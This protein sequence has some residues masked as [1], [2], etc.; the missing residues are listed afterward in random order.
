MNLLIIEDEPLYANNL[1]VLAEKLG[2]QVIGVVDNAAGALQL[3]KQQVPDLALMD[4]NIAGEYDGVETATLLRQEA[5]FPIIFVTSLKDDRTFARAARLG[6]VNYIIK[7]FDDVQLQRAIMLALRNRPVATPPPLEEGSVDAEYLYVKVA[8]R[9]TKVKLSNLLLVSADGHYCELHTRDET[10]NNHRYVLRGSLVDM[11]ER[12]PSPPFLKVHRAHIV[13][14]Q[15]IKSV[16]IREQVI[17][18]SD[19]RQVPLARRMK[20]VFLEKGD[21]LK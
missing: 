6:P 1:L 8:H 16:D 19:G 7:P 4:I 13:N 15:H 21:L 2:H 9:L 5:D 11:D 14:E 10:G 18:L 17:F 12:L 3:V 20:S